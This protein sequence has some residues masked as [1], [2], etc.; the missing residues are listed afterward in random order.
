MKMKKKIIIGILVF[1]CAL[2]A[3]V[4]FRAYVSYSIYKMIKSEDFYDK[5]KEF[6]TRNI[7]DF[8]DKDVGNNNFPDYLKNFYN[9]D[10]IMENYKKFT[11]LE[12]L[13]PIVKFDNQPKVELYDIEANKRLLFEAEAMFGKNVDNFK[14]IVPII[15]NKMKE[16]KINIPPNYKESES[17][18]IPPNLRVFSVNVNYWYIISRLLEDRKEYETSLYLSLASLY[19][20]RDI[21]ANYKNSGSPLMHY[22]GVSAYRKGCDSIFVW[23]SKPK[24][25]YKELSKAI[26]K[27]ILELVKNDYPFSKVVEFDYYAFCDALKSFEA[28][29]STIYSIFP[30]SSECNKILD[31]FYKKPMTYYDKPLY[32]IKNEIKYSFDYFDKLA[33]TENSDFFYYACCN[34]EMLLCLGLIFNFEPYF[35]KNK[36]TNETGLAKMEMAAIALA[37]NSYYCENNKCPESMEELSKWFGSEL[38]KNRLTNK[39]YVLDFEGKHVLYCDNYYEFCDKGWMSREKDE[40]YFNFYYK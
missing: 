6:Y 5:C 15:K 32:E 17:F 37:I 22:I 30:N 27:D 21:R 13:T 35:E 3:F 11:K 14:N 16:K 24:P 19:L 33:K 4:G 26:A 7:D 36:H 2:F 29:V 20:S 18:P 23:A 40:F 38:P 28:E 34:P 31:V 39:P 8:K 1:L 9:Y 10:Y 12:I 25:E